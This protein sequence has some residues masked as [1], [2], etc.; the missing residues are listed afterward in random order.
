MNL[1]GRKRLLCVTMIVLL[2]AGLGWALA[3]SGLR[4]PH[5]WPFLAMHL[6]RLHMLALTHVTLAVILYVL[7]YATLAAFCIPVGP[8]MSAT[9]GALFGVWGGTICAVA[10]ATGGAVVL[11]FLARSAVGRALLHRRMDRMAVVQQRLARD[12]FLAILALR[13]APIVPS[14]LTILA[15]AFA[16]MRWRPFAAATALGLVPATAVFAGIGQGLGGVMA[17]GAAA[18][19]GTLMQPGILVPLLALSAL[20]S[21]PIVVRAWRESGRLSHMWRLPLRATVAAGTANDRRPG[22]SPPD[23]PD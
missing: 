23:P 7:V 21:L 20:A 3:A 16:G 11:F 17:S 15:A 4:L 10:G 2:A 18:D 8:A 14:W 5:L 1:A 13:I 6:S 19:I 12:G 9:G 22:D